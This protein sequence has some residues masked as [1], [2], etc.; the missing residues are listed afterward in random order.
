MPES[1]RREFGNCLTTRHQLASRYVTPLQAGV[2][3]GNGVWLK[4][5]PRVAS[6]V[7]QKQGGLDMPTT[8]PDHATKVADAPPATRMR[9]DLMLTL[10]SYALSFSPA[11][12]TDECRRYVKRLGLMLTANWVVVV[13]IVAWSFL[14]AFAT[15]G[16]ATA[17][18]VGVGYATLVM[19]IDVKLIGS[20]LPEAGLVEASREGA[21]FGLK[22]D[23]RG[24]LIRLGVRLVIAGLMSW[25]TATL[26]ATAIFAPDIEAKIAQLQTNGNIEIIADRR[27]TAKLEMDTAQTR[28]T[29]AQ[30]Q[31]LKDEERLTAA[32][33]KGLPADLQQRR[34]NAGKERDRLM[35]VRSKHQSNLL[36]HRRELA[37]HQGRQPVTATLPGTDPCDQRCLAL[38]DEV[39]A[40][41]E[42]IS[43]TDILLRRVRDV[44]QEID[45]VGAARTRAEAPERRDLIAQAKSALAQSRKELDAATRASQAATDKFSNATTKVD[46]DPR[47]VQESHGLLSRIQ[48]L[49]LLYK[50]NSALLLFSLLLKTVLFLLETSSVLATIITRPPPMAVRWALSRVSLVRQAMSEFAEQE[51]ELLRRESDISLKR[52][53][54]RHAEAKRAFDNAVLAR[55]TAHMRGDK[56]IPS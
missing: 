14:G 20:H 16:V 36:A 13:A 1:S 10:M 18:A 53:D 9:P 54:I 44:E 56:D 17:I 7:L 35:E 6:L 41:R 50:D 27:T 52:Q 23:Q 22:A 25:L 19:L 2:C 39:N 45:A 31:V 38:R 34:E 33:A 37:D 47:H 24:N 8:T 26:L 30:A 51:V 42:A 12:L 4:P 28:K 15:K 29:D 48:A 3:K 32:S 43:Q 55:A 49:D 21:R 5:R 46:A 40:D 11:V